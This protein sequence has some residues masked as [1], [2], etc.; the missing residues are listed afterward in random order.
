M[1]HCLLVPGDRFIVRQFSPVVTIGGGV[2]LDAHPIQKMPLA[3][4]LELLKIQAAGDPKSVLLARISRRAEQGLAL[5][6]VV[7]ETGWREE[8]IEGHLKQEF[9]AVVSFGNMLIQADALCERD[10]SDS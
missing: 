9:P 6:Q 2:V 10:A 4:R 5:S 8:I 7:A 3:A 1:T